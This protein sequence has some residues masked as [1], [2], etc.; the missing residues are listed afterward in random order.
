M[1]VRLSRLAF[2]TLSLPALGQAPRLAGP[3][4]ESLRVREPQRIQAAVD[5]L[6]ALRPALGLG[7]LHTF[8]AERTLT[9]E[10]GQ[11]HVRLQQRFQGVPIFGGEVVAHLDAEGRHLAPTLALVP[12]GTLNV[13]PGLPAGEALAVAHGLLAPSGPYARAPQIE[14]VIAPRLEGRPR[15]RGPRLHGPEVEPEAESEDEALVAWPLAYHIHLELENGREETRHEDFLIHA[16]TGAV[17]ERWNTLHT[18]GAVGSGRSQW[19]GTVSLDTATT[20]GGYELRDTTRGSGG[21]FGHNVT[22]NLHNGTSGT[23][24]IFTDADDAWGDGLPY[25]GTA[26]MSANAQTAAVDGHRGLQSTWDFY[27]RIFGRNGIDGTGKATYSRMHYSSQYD[28]AFWSDSCFCMTYGDGAVGGSVGEA[29]LDT[30]G[31]EMTHGVTAAT[32][33]LRYSGEPGGLNESTS[34]ILGTMVEFWTLGGSGAAIPDQAG[35]NHAN[36]GKF[37]NYKL[38]EN[39]WGHA[40]PNDALRWMHKP[41][42]DGASADFW[43]KRVGHLDVHYSSGVG[44]HFFFLLAHGSQVDSLSENEASPLMNGVTGITG[45]GNDKAARI[46]FRALSAYMTSRTTYAGARTATL[47]AA[48]DLYGDSSVEYAT[49]AT[50]WTA[51]NVR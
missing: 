18:A 38:F 51:V 45:I 42:R 10:L 22:T 40:Y 44:N 3:D 1:S 37:A 46:W 29:D 7:P 47:S 19:Y 24:T 14:L 12:F 15:L 25:N 41:S 34:D 50:A 4:L 48:K 35:S 27:G 8:T 26:G 30:C 5:H 43:T 20:A 9:D 13:T 11:T 2:A 21:T 6:N 23:G 36:G 32:A 33:K 39:S 49:V 28:N 17:L 31:H 16:H